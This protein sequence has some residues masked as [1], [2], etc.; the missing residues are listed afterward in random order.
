MTNLLVLCKQDY[1]GQTIRE[2][3]EKAALALKCT[4]K[5]SNTTLKVLPLASAPI[6]PAYLWSAL[7]ALISTDTSKQ[8]ILFSRLPCCWSFRFSGCL[9]L[10]LRCGLYFITFMRTILTPLVMLNPVLLFKGGF[11]LNITSATST[12]RWPYLLHCVVVVLLLL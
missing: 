7:L 10:F 3:L 11:F 5:K 8:I 4:R 6:E 9:P 2:T 12:T 1:Y